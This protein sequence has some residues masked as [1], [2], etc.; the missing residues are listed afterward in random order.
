MTYKL[1]FS[2]HPSR[3]THFTLESLYNT[4]TVYKVSRITDFAKVYLNFSD[5]ETDYHLVSENNEFLF[6]VGEKQDLV[7]RKFDTEEGNLLN[8]LQEKVKYV[9]IRHDQDN[10]FLVPEFINK[11]NQ[12]KLL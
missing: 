7:L 8:S 12:Y 4:K 2:K 1:G 10:N 9:Y 3:E 5:N 11:F 6:K